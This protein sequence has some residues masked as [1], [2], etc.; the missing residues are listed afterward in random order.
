MRTTPR[1]VT[2]YD[3]DNYTG[4]NLNSMLNVDVN[5]ENYANLFLMRVEDRLLTRI[6][7]TSF[8][9]H[10]YDHL[11]PFQ[12]ENLQRAIIE[13]ADY[14]LRNSDI[15]TDSGYDLEKGKVISSQELYN[16]EICRIAKDYLLE[17]GLLNYNIQNRRRYNNFK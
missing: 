3:Y 16:I 12:K 17:C 15:F 10:D 14:I 5:N 9:V 7:V 4:N 8:R 2:P 1:F 13:Q 6:D 11:T